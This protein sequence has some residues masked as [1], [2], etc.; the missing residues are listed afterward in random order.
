MTT[1]SITPQ[2]S[3]GSIT[4][5]ITVEERGTDEL[6]ITS[7][8]VERGANITDHA[9]KNPAVLDL[10]LAWSNSSAKAAG[11]EGY[12]QRIYQKLLDLQAARE[13]INIVT[14]KRSYSNMLI[15]ALR[16]ATD[17]TTE[18]SLFIDMTC[19]EVIIASTTTTTIPPTAQQAN[20]KVTA[21]P[22]NLGTKQPIPAELSPASQATPGG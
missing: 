5:D 10:R 7:H 11:D 14:G 15:R 19:Q 16:T 21:E 3:V 13:L 4:A 17:E 8:P 2:R 9:Y 1:G 20:P 6:V 18:T 12:V 22:Q